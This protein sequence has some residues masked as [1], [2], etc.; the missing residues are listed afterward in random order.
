M[1]TISAVGDLWRAEKV[2]KY[3]WVRCHGVVTYGRD[4]KRSEKERQSLRR[5]RIKRTV[6]TSVNQR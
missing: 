3:F 5:V 2:R 1:R 6:K 4:E